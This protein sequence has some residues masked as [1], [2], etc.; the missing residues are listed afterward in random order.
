MKQNAFGLLALVVVLALFS[1]G[2]SPSGATTETPELDHVGIAVHDLQKSGEFYEKVM[3]LKRI[4]DPFNDGK[5]L[6]YRVGAHEQLHVISSATAMTHDIV[7]HMAF[8]V[9][10]LPSFMAHLDRMKV[11]YRNFRS[12][13]RTPS[14][15]PDDVKQVYFQDP[16]GY[17]IEVDD[18]KF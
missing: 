4:P 2:F 8:H 13:D 5:H 18:H 3:Q 17:W 9:P 12:D 1:L 16:D 10:S 6:W 11:K 7:V 15:R 14:I